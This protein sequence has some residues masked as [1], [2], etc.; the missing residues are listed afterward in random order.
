MGNIKFGLQLC[1]IR[2][3]P[4]KV[5]SVELLLG[6]L[7]LWSH[8][9]WSRPIQHLFSNLF[10]KAIPKFW[11]ALE[12]YFLSCGV[13]GLFNFGS[14]GSPTDLAKGSILEQT[15]RQLFIT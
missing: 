15:V 5:C 6:A 12:L 11:W 4:V 1:R 9:V 13:L 8:L 3:L 10:S 7:D 2:V 14:F